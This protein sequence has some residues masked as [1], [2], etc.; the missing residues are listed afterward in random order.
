M[1]YGVQLA[2]VNWM[3]GTMGE[4]APQLEQMMAANPGLPTIRASLAMAFAQ[5]QQFEDALQLLE[6]FA[7]TNY[8]LPQDTVWL[9][10]MTEYAAAAI[11]CGDP[12]YAQDLYSILEPWADQFSSAGGLTAEGPVC[13]YLGGL[14]TVLGQFDDAERHLLHA[15]GLCERNGMRFFAAL[16]NLIRGR[17]LLVRGLDG[18]IDTARELLTSVKQVAEENGYAGL[19]VEAAAAL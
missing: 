3:R 11:A 17:L 10:G 6:E 16:T 12:R 15:A 13:L 8:F 18:D 2:A 9:N 7:A 4:L 5:A 19:A 14:A 1:C